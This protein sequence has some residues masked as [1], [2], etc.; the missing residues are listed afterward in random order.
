[1]YS[2]CQIATL[3]SRFPCPMR[4][5][6]LAPAILLLLAA[7]TAAPKPY[8]E[9]RLPKNELENFG[10][11]GQE[12]TFAHSNFLAKHGAE[13]PAHVL[14]ELQNSAESTTGSGRTYAEYETAQ[15]RFCQELVSPCPEY[16]MC[17]YCQVF[18]SGGSTLVAASTA[19]I[20]P[21][22]VLLSKYNSQWSVFQGKEKLF[23]APMAYGPDGV[24]QSIQI[25][26][27]KPAVAFTRTVRPSK[28]E[29]QPMPEMAPDIFYDGAF[30]NAKYGVYGSHGVFSY[31]G[32]IGFIGQKD[33]TEYVSD[34]GEKYFKQYVYFDGK[35]VSPAFDAIRTESCCDMP[36]TRLRVFDNGALVFVG[37][38]DHYGILTEIDLNA[39]T[40]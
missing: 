4:P 8:T 40:P 34:N 13:L 2:Q 16:S 10:Y 6:V 30:F 26:E 21:N 3:T 23:S 19:A 32:K 15:L 28:S 33:Q 25:F 37:E 11:Q 39:S 14:K 17:R 38:R 20:G 22:N 29:D 31:K 18:G 1:M 36:S 7:C 27:G 9:I 12:E 5:L 24:I 35:P